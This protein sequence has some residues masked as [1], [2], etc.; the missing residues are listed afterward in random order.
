MSGTYVAYDGA[1][2]TPDVFFLVCIYVELKIQ[3][4]VATVAQRKRREGGNHIFLSCVCNK[5][6]TA[7]TNNV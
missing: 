2:V 1:A 6:T 7:R 3:P 5:N 4:A